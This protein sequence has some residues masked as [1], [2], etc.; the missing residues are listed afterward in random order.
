MG[1]HEPA[2]SVQPIRVDSIVVTARLRALRE[3]VVGELQASIQ[4]IGL[5]APITIR[6]PNGRAVFPHLVSGAHRLEAARRLGWETISCCI[7]ATDKDGATLAE[8]DENLARGELSPAERA[9]HVAK[10]KEIYERQHPETKQGKAPGKAGGGKIATKNPESGSFVK[11]TAAKTARSRSAVAADA[12]RHKHIPQIAA[13]VG[14]SLD[15]GDELDALA[16]LTPE[17]Q[18]PIIEQAASGKNTS[19]KPAAKRYAR[20]ARI[21]AMAVATERASTE[22]GAKLY[23]VIYCD[24]PWRFEPYSRITGMDRAAD[25]H[26]P[27]MTREQLDALELPAADD[28]ALFLWATIPMLPE[29][30]AFMTRHDFVYRSAYAWHKPGPGTGYWSQVDQLELL[31]VGTRGQ[32]PAPSP[33]TQPPQVQTFSRGD[34]SVKPEAFAAMIETMFPA[35]AK[36]EMFARAPRSGWDVWGNEAA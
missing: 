17:Q 14:T 1:E 2:S 4:Q 13:C 26:Y 32:V 25:N 7:L 5:L 23:N 29:A 16:R 22:L 19:A 31:L 24:P 10:R 11:D 3:D 36:L 20:A 30:L 28:C 27:T 34:H 6:R 8:I 33:G 12:A 21:D 18:A 9:I 15:Q 35:V